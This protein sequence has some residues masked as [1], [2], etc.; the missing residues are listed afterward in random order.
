M[1][2]H[3]PLV[4]VNHSHD[5]LNLSCGCRASRLGDQKNIISCL[6]GSQLAMERLPESRVLDRSMAM[7]MGPTPPGTGV[8]ISALLIASS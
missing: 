7:V 2:N 3:S 1:I 8:I 6:P 4:S 5:K